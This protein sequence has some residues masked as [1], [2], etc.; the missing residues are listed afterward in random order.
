MGATGGR[1][2]GKNYYVDPTVLRQ[3]IREH[4]AA[5]AANPEARMSDELGICL[6]KIARKFASN[7]CF[8]GYTYREDFEAD[9]VVKMI[10]AVD[11][12]DPD[13]RR[14]PFG[15]LTQT[16]YRVIIN[17]IKKEKKYRQRQNEYAEQMYNQ[18]AQENGLKPWQA[19]EGLEGGEGKKRDGDRDEAA[20]EI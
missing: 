14:S 10:K 6:M 8:C 18:Y 13:D 20:P 17:F 11:H 9:A 2:E 3:L 7:P 15:Y 12:I 16:C 1:E 19:P 4:K 5:K